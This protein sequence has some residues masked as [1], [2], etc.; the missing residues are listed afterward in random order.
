M[1]KHII[2]VSWL[3]AALTVLALVAPCPARSMPVGRGYVIHVNDQLSVQVYGDPSL[4][5]VVTVLP[6]GDIFYPLV[7]RISVGGQTPDQAANTIAR[8]LKKFI[9]K[10][11]VSVSVQSQGQIGVLVLGDVKNPGKYLLGSQAKVS[12][13]IAAAGGLGPIDGNYPDA[14][15]ADSG[16]TVRTVS[17]QQLF[18]LGNG[19]V[20]SPLNDGTAVY[21]PMPVVITV[22]VLGSVDHPGE[23]SLREGDDIAIAIAKAGASA[24]SNPDLNHVQ[25]RRT[26]PDGQTVSSEINLYEQLKGGAQTRSFK[27]Q[28]DDIVY[29]P[30]AKHSIGNFI[31]NSLGG[32][33]AALRALVRLP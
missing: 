23:I 6:G 27:M 25:V 14:R 20:D 8:A 3:A 1:N 15:I 13:A 2:A 19:S 7:G 29:V 30:Q 17:L 33:F 28:K 5:Q 24:A 32:L 21:I 31:A 11:L 18:Q 26:L 10:P 22:S 4:T 12:D 9:R 16:G